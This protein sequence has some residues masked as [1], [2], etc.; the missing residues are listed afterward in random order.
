M[1]TKKHTDK[2]KATIW[3]P[4]IRYDIE[5]TRMGALG[6]I[7]RCLRGQDQRSEALKQ[8]HQIDMDMTARE[9][10]AAADDADASATTN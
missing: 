2:V 1:A 3:T 9:M 10:K 6:V 4:D 5:A 7:F 8:L